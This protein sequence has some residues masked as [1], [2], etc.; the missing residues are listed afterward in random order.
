MGIKIATLLQEENYFSTEIF[1]H[2]TGPA[3]GVPVLFLVPVQFSSQFLILGLGT[4]FCATWRTTL[5]LL[6]T[7]ISP[8]YTGVVNL[9]GSTRALPGGCFAECP[10]LVTLA[11]CLCPTWTEQT[12]VTS[13]C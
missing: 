1:H 8:S 10:L 11:P 7:V 4:L 13:V 2:C 6:H 9:L 3:G 12:L 5:W